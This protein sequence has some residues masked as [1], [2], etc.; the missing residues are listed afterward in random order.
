M[1]IGVLETRCVGAE[2]TSLGSLP[3]SWSAR[4]CRVV[5][6]R[7]TACRSGVKARRTFRDRAIPGRESRAADDGS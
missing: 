1:T 5:I 2:C 4:A 7:S 6:M 3:K